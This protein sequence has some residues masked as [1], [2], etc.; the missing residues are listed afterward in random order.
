[1]EDPP[2]TFLSVASPELIEEC[3]YLLSIPYFQPIDESALPLL[4]FHEGTTDRRV[5][6]LLTCHNTICLSVSDQDQFKSLEN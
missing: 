1:M 4:S 5:F 2:Q 3:I 6:H